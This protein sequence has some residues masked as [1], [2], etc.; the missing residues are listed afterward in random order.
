MAPGEGDHEVGETLLGEMLA[1][2]LPRRDHALAHRRVVGDRTQGAEPEPVELVAEVEP[3]E[4][5]EQAL[6]ELVGIPDA[7]A[8]EV[9]PGVLDAVAGVAGLHRL[10]D[11][12][13]AEVEALGAQRVHA[14]P[15]EDVV[16]QR[17]GE[18]H[19]LD[20]R[21]G[22]APRV[23]AARQRREVVLADPDR[24]PGRR[25]EPG[26][27]ADEFLRDRPGRDQGDLPGE[28]HLRVADLDQGAAL[29]IAQLQALQ[30]QRPAEAGRRALG[31]VLGRQEA[32]RAEMRRHSLVLD[33]DVEALLVPVDQL[34][35]GR[36]QV[37]VG[38]QDRHELAD[39][40]LAL[41]GE[42]AADRVEQERCH[43]REQVVEIF[44][45]ELA[46]VDPQAQV[47]EPVEAAA[48]LRA[49]PAAGVVQR[50]RLQAVEHLGDAPGQGAGRDLALAAETDDLPPQP[51]DH[52]HLHGDHAAG[53]DTEPDVLH[54]DEGQRRRGLRAQEHRHH[55]RVADEGAD[56]LDLVPD[57][58]RG[59]GGFHLPLRLRGEAQH[60][61]EQ[62][63][64]Q[65][66]QHPL[67]ENA[68]LE[69][70]PELERAVDQDEAEEQR[71]QAEQQ[72]EPVELEPLEQVRLAAAQ[73]GGP[74]DGELEERRGRLAVR[75]GLPRDRVVD[76]ALRQVERGE[77]ERERR[78]H[79]GADPELRDL[80]VAP[81]IRE[82][83]RLKRAH[84]VLPTKA[85][86]GGPTAESPQPDA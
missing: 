10:V 86:P 53:R 67:A 51:R 23:V 11:P 83:P 73:E 65:A 41:Q 54:H 20:A 70:D 85:R 64:P 29:R 34:L 76:D 15:V 21:V 52:G 77:I 84:R 18:Q 55:D 9:D 43:L 1:Q 80:G 26:E 45:R 44:D 32:L 3:A 68:L 31:F 39:V 46:A 50:H 74:L 57:D 60:Q 2:V 13:L 59:L 47:V 17:P 7:E 48:D 27:H 22:D 6:V 42:V 28:A 25:L 71:R 62:L 56:R 14:Q 81:D 37:A 82:Q 61:R 30:P 79:D 24:A 35:E 36:R 5:V 49:F 63:E 66:A 40:E 12:R 69:V 38:G 72:L 19:G 4:Q 75:V 58:R 33:L 78:Q 16:A 8:L